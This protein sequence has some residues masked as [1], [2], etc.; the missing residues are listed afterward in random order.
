M[1][2]RLS[3]YMYVNRS[4]PGRC[5]EALFLGKFRRRHEQQ[6]IPGRIRDRGGQA[7]HGARALGIGCGEAVVGVS[8]RTLYEWIKRY[9]LPE[10][11]RIEQ[12]GLTSRS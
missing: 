7:G 4:G 12:K 8:Q 9:S 1:I 5:S 11:D 3:V 2:S 10:S 6:A